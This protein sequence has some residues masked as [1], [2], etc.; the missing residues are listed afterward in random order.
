MFDTL[1]GLPVHALV[2]HGVVVLLPLAV[3]GTLAVAVRG[4]WRRRYAGLNALVALV[5]LALVPVATES[6]E[7][8]EARVGDPGQHAALGSSL[9][10]FAIPLAAVAVL[11]WWRGRAESRSRTPGR[12]TRATAV[13]AVVAVLVALAAGVQVVRVG[14]TGARAAWGSVVANT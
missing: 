4:A 6:G 3:L 14:D 2:V 11:L 1:N 13:L 5:A 12:P 8:L 7:A 9:L 10:W